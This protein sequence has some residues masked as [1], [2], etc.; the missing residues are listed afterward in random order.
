MKKLLSKYQTG[1]KIKPY[2]YFRN[3]DNGRVWKSEY[4]TWDKAAESANFSRNEKWNTPLNI[5]PEVVITGYKPIELQ[6]FYP[7]I[8]EYPLT[9]H[10][11]LSI[12]ITDNI[13]K[14]YGI[15]NNSKLVIDKLSDAENYNLITNNCADATLGY[16]NYIFG[17][18]ESPMLFTTP[19]DVRDYAITQLG[20]KVVKKDGVDTVIIPRNKENADKLSRRALDFR[21]SSKDTRLT[22]RFRSKFAKDNQHI[23]PIKTFKIPGSSI[24]YKRIGYSPRQPYIIKPLVRAFNN[25]SRDFAY[26]LND[27]NNY[28]KSIF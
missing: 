4:Q 14:E 9:G 23:F 12:P 11:S 26:F 19:G 24:E 15:N 8:S 18:K 6:T 5:A 1:N 7:L 3:N 13:A 25:N 10:S 20:G 22:S 28:I 2:I 17:T 21:K 27:A 16:L